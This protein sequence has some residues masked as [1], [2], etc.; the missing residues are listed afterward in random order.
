MRIID[1]II[2]QRRKIQMMVGSIIIFVLLVSLLPFEKASAIARD[3][4]NPKLIFLPLVFKNSISSCPDGPEQWLCLFNQYRVTAGVNPVTH[5]NI[6]SDGLDLHTTYLIN[7]PKQ[8]EIDVHG[9]TAC[10]GWTETGRKAGSESNMVW[11]PEPNY[12]VK[13]SVDI[14]IQFARHRYGMLHPDLSQSG[15]DLSCNS[16]YCAAGI[17]VLAGLEPKSIREVVYPAENQIGFPKTEFP[18]T[19]AFYTTLSVSTINVDSIK[20]VDKNGNLV[21]GTTTIYNDYVKEVVF[22]PETSLLPNQNYYI[23]MK[24]KIDGNPKFRSW[25]FTTAP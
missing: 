6:Y 8:A 19:W 21:Q 9:E 17:N 20:L 2:R 5:N 10:D 11:N 18:I 13:Q 16:N 22:T 7:C 12:T 25:S 14:W 23:E 15:F 4:D 24:I 3:Q 1:L